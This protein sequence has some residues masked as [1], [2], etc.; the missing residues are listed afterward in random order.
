MCSQEKK[1]EICL[2]FLY[3]CLILENVNKNQY[4]N[5]IERNEKK[6]KTFRAAD[7]EYN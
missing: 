6:K 5:E 4:T 7:N 1:T 3:D 2:S